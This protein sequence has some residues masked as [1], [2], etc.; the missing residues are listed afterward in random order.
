MAQQRFS[1]IWFAG[2]CFALCMAVLTWNSSASPQ[3]KP[4]RSTEAVQPPATSVTK[5]ENNVPKEAAQAAGVSYLQILHPPDDIV[6]AGNCETRVAPVTLRAMKEGVRGPLI[7]G[8]GLS[9]ADSKHKLPDSA[10]ELVQYQSGK[11]GCE[12]EFVPVTA[13]TMVPSAELTKVYIQLRKEWVRPGSY[14]GDLLLAAQGDTSAQTVPLKVFVRPR[15]AWLW[16]FIAILA[17]TLLSWWATV[18]LVRRQ[19][20]GANE[21]LIAR[22]ESL[23]DNLKD[24]LDEME[25][26]GAPR[27][28]RT[29][30]HISNIRRRKLSQ[31]L[32]DR[33]LAVLAGV[34]VPAAAEITVLEEIEGLTRVIQDGIGELFQLWQTH[35]AQRAVLGPFFDQMDALGGRVDAKNALEPDITANITAAKAAVAASIGPGAPAALTAP[36]ILPDFRQEAAVVQRLARATYWLDAISIVVVVMLGMYVLVWKNPGFGTL[37]DFFVAFGWGVG[38]KF[39]TDAARLAPLD[40]R[41]TLGVKIPSP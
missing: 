41:T 35:A 23:L 6:T 13:E 38:L 22:L 20:L 12:K 37:G 14:A 2:F 7:V 36:H 33:V 1:L 31:L 11:G 4:A 5:V 27:S 32:D 8:G 21:V 26:A 24:D 15:Y 29:L 18:W 16:S 30:T 17:G 34:T 10:F 3:Q 40:V 19:Q 39:G 9:D 28:E 25:H